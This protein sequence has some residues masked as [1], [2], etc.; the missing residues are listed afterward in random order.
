MRSPAII[1]NQIIS[2][3]LIPH[4]R[5][6]SQGS[7]IFMAKADCFKGGTIWFSKVRGATVICTRVIKEGK[8]HSCCLEF[9]QRGEVM[10]NWEEILP[11]W[12]LVFVEKLLNLCTRNKGIILRQADSSRILETSSLNQTFNR[13]FS[14]Y[15]N[16]II[17]P[18]MMLNPLTSI[19]ITL[20]FDKNQLLFLLQRVQEEKVS[21]LALLLYLAI[22]KLP[23]WKDSPWALI[24]LLL[25]GVK[26]KKLSKVTTMT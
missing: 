26:L 14:I 4:I 22:K 11:R 9:L 23:W 1:E 13:S 18:F 21:Y 17:H 20:W 16:S 7:K 8:T 2:R 25:E 12:C 19:L 15:K 6:S 24:L 5:R 3:C 10:W